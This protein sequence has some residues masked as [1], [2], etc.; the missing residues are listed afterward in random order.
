LTA[1]LAVESEHQAH[2]FRSAE[3]AERIAGFAR[4]GEEGPPAG[5]M[6]PSGFPAQVHGGTSWRAG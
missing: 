4:P 1:Q 2:A 6:G 3:A 5:A